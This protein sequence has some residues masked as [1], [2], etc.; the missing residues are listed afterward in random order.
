MS[1]GK[2]I[3]TLRKINSINQKDFAKSINV[4]Q[5]ALSLYES[6]TNSPSIIVLKK[7]AETYKCSTDWLLD[8]DI[9]MEDKINSPGQILE[10]LMALETSD[11]AG[12]EIIPSN[13]GIT[14]TIDREDETTGKPCALMKDYL[15]HKSD[16][17]SIKD[18]D[19]RKICINT[20]IQKKLTEYDIECELTNLERS[21]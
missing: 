7:I 18:E 11:L 17:A 1:I 19:I 3:K 9:K 5:S 13:S 14:I 16:F 21:E 2:N 8:V 4:T 15:E 6:D 10:F 12:I 20:W